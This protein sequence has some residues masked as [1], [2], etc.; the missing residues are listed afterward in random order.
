MERHD[1]AGRGPIARLAT[2]FCTD[3]RWRHWLEFRRV[4]G[5]AGTVA[6]SWGKAAK[7][8]SGAF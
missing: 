4:F 1:G 8:L 7:R 3:G 6:A 2:N 5:V